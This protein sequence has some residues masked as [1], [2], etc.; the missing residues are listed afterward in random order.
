MCRDNQVQMAGRAPRGLWVIQAPQGS[1]GHPVTG[2]NRGSLDP[3]APRVREA[4]RGSKG[5]KV[6]QETGVNQA[7]MDS[8]GHR[9]H[10]AILD[11]LGTLG[12]QAKMAPGVSQGSR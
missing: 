7:G 1:Q 8:R 11:S 5:F 4:S 10:L 2:D 9:V 3:Q 6:K 12:I